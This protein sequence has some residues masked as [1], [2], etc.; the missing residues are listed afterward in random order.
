M[1]CPVCLNKIEEESI[2]LVCGADIDIELDPEN[3]KWRLLKTLDS[4]I[5]AEMLKANLESA[6]I[7]VFL[8]SKQDSAYRMSVNDFSAVEVLIPE[9]FLNEAK[10][11]LKDINEE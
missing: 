10:N 1:K 8:F 9:Q 5:E 7:P 6:E 11:I 4:Q 2:C 3:I